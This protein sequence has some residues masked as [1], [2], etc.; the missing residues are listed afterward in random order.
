MKFS[1]TLDGHTVLHCLHS[2]KHGLVRP[3]LTLF[4]VGTTKNSGSRLRARPASSYLSLTPHVF[5]STPE[6]KMVVNGRH[7]KLIHIDL[8]S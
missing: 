5:S 4:L 7:C 6:P 8:P 3:L 1:G 2:M